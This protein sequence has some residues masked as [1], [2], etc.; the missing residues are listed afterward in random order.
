MVCRRKSAA[1]RP[2]NPPP[3]SEPR[4]QHFPL[5]RRPRLRRASTA[6]TVVRPRADTLREL[7]L[8]RYRTGLSLAPAGENQD[9]TLETVKYHLKPTLAPLDP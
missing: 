6:S 5:G 7:T 3:A 9:Q 4:R 2:T 1:S 8:I